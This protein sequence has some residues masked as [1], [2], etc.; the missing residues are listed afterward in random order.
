MRTRVY[1]N[2]HDPAACEWLRELMKKG[3]IPEGDIDERSIADVGP[4]DLKRYTQCHFFAGIG[5]WAYALRLAGVPDLGCWTGSCPCQPFSAAGKKRGTEDE[6]HLWPEF[7]RLIAERRPRLVFGEQVEEAIA[8]GWLDLV[9]SGLEAEG[10]ACGAVVLGAHSVGAPHIR[11][12]LYWVADSGGIGKRHDA[13]AVGG[14][15]RQAEGRQSQA[16]D[17]AEDAEHGGSTGGLGHCDD[18]RQL[19]GEIR[20]EPLKGAGKLAAG[21]PSEA[22]GMGDDGEAASRMGV[23][24]PPSTES[25]MADPADGGQQHN[26]RGYAGRAI[27]QDQARRQPR[28]VPSGTGATFWDAAEWLPCEDGKARPIEPGIFPVAYGVPQRMVLLKGYGN[29]VVPQ[30]AAAFVKALIG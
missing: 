19:Q 22:C 29:A 12:R 26:P 8:Y 11:Q 16:R 15:E 10:Y 7:L 6:R 28:F 17:K 9:S 2:E 5:G 25:R 13:G 30:V 4:D 21:Q 1:Y 18:V 20:D 3:S 27:T 23:A 24:D 14:A